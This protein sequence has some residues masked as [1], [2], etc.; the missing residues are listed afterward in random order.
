M[1]LS[2]LSHLTP[3]R[4]RGF[5]KDPANYMTMGLRKLDLDNW[6]TVD[7]K[8][9][10]FYQARRQLLSEKKQEVL[11]VKPGGEAACGEL[12]GEVVGFLTK[13]YPEEYEIFEG[14]QRRKWVRNRMTKEEFAISMP[15]NVHPL[16]VVARLAMEDFNVLIK[17]QFT[18]NHHLVASATLFPA[19]W[20]LRDRIGNSVTEIHKPVPQWKG[21]SDIVNLSYFSRIDQKSCMERSSFFVQ[22]RPPGMNLADTLF[23]QEPKDFFPG[24]IHNLLP[25][26]IIIRHERQ[27]FRRL[28]KS[29]AVIFIVKTSIT[30]LVHFPKEELAGLAAEIR[31]WPEDIAEY[32]GR[33]LWQRPVLGYCEGRPTA[34]E[35]I[36]LFSDAGSSVW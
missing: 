20:R 18:G 11:Q 31:S 6:L 2:D 27:T 19:G 14:E 30:P 24:M 12:L 23:V 29:G 32:K 5:K 17:S 33:G 10:E 13:K 8:Y 26:N 21:L 34:L 7:G 36:D 22:V 25:H 28:P 15:Y 1:P 9:Y 4:S 16:E 35:D 3:Y